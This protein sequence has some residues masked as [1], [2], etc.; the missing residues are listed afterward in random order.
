M[1]YQSE[2]SLSMFIVY[3]DMCTLILRLFSLY[4]MISNFFQVWFYFDNVS[5]YVNDCY[6]LNGEPP[7]DSHNLIHGTC[8]YYLIWKKIYF[9]VVIKLRIL[10]WEISLNY[11]GGTK[12][13]SPVSL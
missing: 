3:N 13:H 9:A 11:P 5:S 12:M 6:R 2:N 10:R 7:K 8:K 4:C 1:I